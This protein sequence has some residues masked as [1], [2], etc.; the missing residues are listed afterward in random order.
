MPCIS[1]QSLQSLSHGMAEVKER[2]DISGEIIRMNCPNCRKDVWAMLCGLTVPL[3]AP[4][5]LGRGTYA[6]HFAVRPEC[7][8]P[9]FYYW[10]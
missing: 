3:A 5:P 6:R 2:G 1:S 7:E 4:R 8:F 9:A 10:N